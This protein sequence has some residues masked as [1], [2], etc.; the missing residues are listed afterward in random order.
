MIGARAIKHDEH[1]LVFEGY[2]VDITSRKDLE[3]QLIRSEKELG[4]ILNN[5]PD[6]IY[7]LD[8]MGKITYVNNA[9]KRYGYSPD[10]LLGRDVEE[11]IHP[12]D[13]ERLRNHLKE[14]RTGDRRTK[15]M[16]IRLVGRK[17]GDGHFETMS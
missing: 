4:S 8:P 11:L 2:Y 15:A 9:V 1:G 13:R 17:G 6:I 7:R 10:E 3:A 16:T 12:N 5:T 14:R